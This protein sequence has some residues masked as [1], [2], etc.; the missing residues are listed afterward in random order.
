MQGSWPQPNQRRSKQALWATATSAAAAIA[1]NNCKLWCQGWDSWVAFGSMPLTAM[2]GLLVA[3]NRKESWLKT[4]RWGTEKRIAPT[5]RHWCK[6]G[7]KPVVS[8]SMIKSCWGNAV[9][10]LGCCHAAAIYGDSLVLSSQQ[11]TKPA[12]ICLGFGGANAVMPCLL[13]LE[14]R[15]RPSA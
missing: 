4:Q 6:V 8:V 7:S 11:N 10:K 12:R 9:N 5:S 14:T 1:S 13:P 3:G 2:A 15:L